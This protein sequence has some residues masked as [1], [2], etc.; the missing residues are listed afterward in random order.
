[1]K[2]LSLHLVYFFFISSC[3]AQGTVLN[4][5]SY[6]AVGDGITVNTK[7][8]QL[9]VD[10]CNK[11]GGGDV[12]IPPGIF[13]TGTIH[14]KSNINLYLQSGAV[15]EGST[16]LADYELFYAG[17]PYSSVHKGMLFT[18]NAENITISGYGQIDGN[19]DHFFELDK[20]KK[21]SAEDTKFTRQ[22]ENF[23]HVENEIGDGP[24]VPK[25]RPYQMFVFS[26][27]KRVT[28]KDIFIT[29][30]PFWCMH[31]ADCDA[32]RLNGVRLW[33]NLLAPNA[34]GVD[35]TSC[36]NVLI[37]DCDIRAGDDA[38]AIVGYNHHFEIPGFKHLIH[39][40]GN[41]IISSCNLQSYSSGIR[42]GYLDQNTVKNIHVNNVNITNA[43]RGIG[44]FVRDEGSL[45]NITF[46]NIN[47]ETHLRTGD[48]WGNGE[49]IHISAVRGKENVKLGQIKHVLFENIICRGENGM[50][51][52]GSDESIIEDVSFDHIR[53]QLS[54][55]KLNEVAGGNIDLR[56]SS[57]EKSLF[58][59]DI[60]GL[61]AAYVNGLLINDF[62]L[63]WLNTRMPFFTNGIELSHFTGV[64]IMN[65]DGSPSP[66][67]PK[68]Y[69]IYAEQGQGFKTDNNRGVLLQNVH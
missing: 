61:L 48:W 69:R 40:C 68:A 15:L 60:P 8:I 38:I 30:A 47:I 20:A 54:D 67:D 32:V 64:E 55:S 34:D 56:G 5:K 19:G 11:N 22:K 17:A 9:A 1:M 6:G 13:V 29:K 49:P 65:F 37:E 39:P 66:V 28:I 42:I 31:F 12:V 50:L 3:I 43:T 18:E 62:K 45:E 14:L 4:I 35:I 24:I 21:L 33:N 46:S 53:F 26:N 27:C 41:I 57:L 36:T 7:A 2:F 59:R 44:I 23:R 16:N 25:E 10:A 63:E 52:Y 51:V 58:S